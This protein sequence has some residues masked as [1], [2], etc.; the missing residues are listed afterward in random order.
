MVKAWFCKQ[1][2]RRFDSRLKRIRIRKNPQN[3]YANEE[4]Y[5]TVL[6]AITAGERIYN[7]LIELKIEGQKKWSLA[8]YMLLSLTVSRQFWGGL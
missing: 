1:S 4:D 8:S 6:A 3:Y 7:K 2:I 5:K